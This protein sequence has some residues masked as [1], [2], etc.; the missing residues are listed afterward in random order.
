MY[1]VLA[2]R[3]HVFV[4]ALSGTRS[5]ESGHLPWTFLLQHGFSSDWFDFSLL[6]HHSPAKE[7]AHLNAFPEHSYSLNYLR[8]KRQR[9]QMLNL[10]GT[11]MSGVLRPRPAGLD[12]PS[13]NRYAGDWSSCGENYFLNPRECLEE[14]DYDDVPSED[15]ESGDDSSRAEELDAPAR[16]PQPSPGEHPFGSY[17]TVQTIDSAVDHRAHLKDLQESID[18]LIGNLEKELN[19]NKLNM[20]Y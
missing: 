18:T 2:V 7:A 14:A 11:E 20:S 16:P 12:S 5:V 13:S 6:V 9:P 8:P 3:L 15:T 19:K 10:S 17:L 1:N 4:H